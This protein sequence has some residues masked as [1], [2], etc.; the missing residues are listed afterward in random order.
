MSQ[1]RT[2][3]EEGRE[4]AAAR[5]S[6]TARVSFLRFFPCFPTLAP[7]LHP[8]QINKDEEIFGI[9]IHWLEL[10]LPPLAFPSPSLSSSYPTASAP[11]VIDPVGRLT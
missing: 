9:N 11:F 8:D 3:A 7:G 5:T 10:R 6:N 4:S 2:R 1:T